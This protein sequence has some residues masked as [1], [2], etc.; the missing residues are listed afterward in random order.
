MI[1]ASILFTFV[2]K[3]ERIDNRKNHHKKK[4]IVVG[5]KICAKK[6]QK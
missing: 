4:S 6:K 5:Q 1:K 3:V 2:L